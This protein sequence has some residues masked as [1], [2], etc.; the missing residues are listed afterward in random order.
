[1]ASP[2]T[3]NHPAPMSYA[4]SLMQPLG[5]LSTAM[6]EDFV[7][8]ED[9][10]KITEG[11]LGPNISFSQRVEDKLDLDWSCAVIIKLMGRPNTENAYD[12]MKKALTRKWTLRGPW[13]TLVV[14][15]WR[16]DFDPVEEKINCMAIWTRINGLPVKYFKQYTMEKVGQMLGKVVKVDQ[17]TLAQARGKFCR[18]CVEVNLNEPLKPFV[19]LDDK[20][21]GVVYEGISTIC[22]N[23]GVYGHVKDHCPYAKAA[24]SAK[25]TVNDVLMVSTRPDTIDEPITKPTDVGLQSADNV[26][27]SEASQKNSYMAPTNTGTETNKAKMGPWMIMNYKNRKGNN[28]NQ[29]NYKEKIGTGSRFT[30]LQTDVNESG[31]VSNM[32]QTPTKPGNGNNDAT[33]EPKIVKFWKRVQEKSDMALS[34][35]HTLKSKT[36][37]EDKKLKSNAT[38]EDNISISARKDVSNARVPLSEISNHRSEVSF[39]ASIS[40]IN[41]ARKGGKFAISSSA[42]N[43]VRS[44]IMKGVFKS[45]TTKIGSGFTLESLKSGTFM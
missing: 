20:P 6:M 17:H 16:P 29:R 21:Y 37:K 28:A 24:E 38:M 32:T 42:N 22:F 5:R 26:T 1:M 12:F 39:G 27:V 7:L 23:C 43:L 44:P 34:N 18:I 9:D 2:E 13:Q 33:N 35:D 11:K 25:P 14:Q 30:P 8:G 41:G 19:E 31:E 15:K 10:Y 36:T 3:V 4:N 40:K 45:E